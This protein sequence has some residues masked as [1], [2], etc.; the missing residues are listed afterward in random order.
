MRSKLLVVVLMLPAMFLVFEQA[1]KCLAD[2]TVVQPITYGAPVQ[3]TVN[4][5]PNEPIMLPMLR[6]TKN[7][8]ITVPEGQRISIDGAEVRGV[9]ESEGQLREVTVF[10]ADRVT[11]QVEESK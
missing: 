10:G 8:K 9:F 5:T 3:I 11:I 6:E 1:S 7:L 4:L 2:S